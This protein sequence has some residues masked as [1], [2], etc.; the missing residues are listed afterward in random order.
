MIA[1]HTSIIGGPCARNSCSTPFPPQTK[2]KT[3]FET[4]LSEEC[5]D[6]QQQKHQHGLYFFGNQIKKLIEFCFFGCNFQLK[7]KS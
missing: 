6:V 5:N 7:Q 3:F 2:R 4:Y 1:D